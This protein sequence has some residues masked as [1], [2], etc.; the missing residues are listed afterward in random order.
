VANDSSK[1]RIR[2][3]RLPWRKSESCFSRAGLKEANFVARGSSV[4]FGQCEHLCIGNSD[5]RFPY[6]TGLKQV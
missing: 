2:R 4:P 1:S 6:F 5:V 3:S